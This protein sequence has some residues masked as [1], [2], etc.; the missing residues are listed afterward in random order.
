[1]TKIAL[2]VGVISVL[3]GGLWLLQGLG[4]VHTSGP[5]FVSPIASPFRGLR[6]RG[7]SPD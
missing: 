4:I 5:S 7:P 2:V 3:P 1:M 6:E